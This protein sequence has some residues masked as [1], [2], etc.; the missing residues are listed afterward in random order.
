MRIYLLGDSLSSGSSSPGAKFAKLLTA[1]GHEVRVNAKVGRSAYGFLRLEDGANQLAEA[2]AW[3][4][5]RVYIW[6]GTND[7]GLAIGPVT[8]AMRRIR[9][10]FPGSEVWAF[11][12]PDFPEWTEEHALAGLVLG[13]MLGVY[14]P[15]F[16]NLVPLTADM[17]EAPMRASDGVHFTAAGGTELAKRM[18]KAASGGGFWRMLSGVALGAMVWYFFFR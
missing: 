12:P 3:K 8:T 11:G 6:L 13:A 10:A 16:V 2:A 5:A 14:E 4:P 18:M 9:D 1:Q 15:R 17:L 7:I